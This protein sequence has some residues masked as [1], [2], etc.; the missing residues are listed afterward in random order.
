MS[1]ERP[2]RHS[3]LLLAATCALVGA[4]MLSLTTVA[5]GGIQIRRPSAQLHHKPIKF[6]HKRTMQCDVQDRSRCYHTRGDL[7]MCSRN[8]RYFPWVSMKPIQY[9]ISTRTRIKNNK[10]V[11]TVWYRGHEMGGDYSWFNKRVEHV[12]Y[13]A[14]SGYRITAATGPSGNRYWNKYGAHAGKTLLAPSWFARGLNC[15]HALIYG[16]QYGSDLYQGYRL[17]F[18][19]TV[20]LT[21][22]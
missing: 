8:T 3:A 7:D 13:Q 10:V 18:P 4:S 15:N 11:L 5:E 6:S 12:L 1:Y 20:S 22:G 9:S 19:L 21:P 16:D 2:R 14:P 17:K